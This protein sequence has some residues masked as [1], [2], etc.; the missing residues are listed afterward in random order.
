MGEL[1][2]R[3]M[4]SEA[5]QES[6]RDTGQRAFI[7]E[8][9]ETYPRSRSRLRASHAASSR[10]ETSQIQPLWP[11]AGLPA[12][13]PI[14]VARPRAKS[15]SQTWCKHMSPE[16]EVPRSARSAHH[17]TGERNQATGGRGQ[18]QLAQSPGR[19]AAKGPRRNCRDAVARLGGAG[20]PK[21]CDICPPEE[22]DGPPNW[23]RSWPPVK[24]PANQMDPDS[25]T[26]VPTEPS[27]LPH[28]TTSGSA[29]RCYLWSS[30]ATAGRRSDESSMA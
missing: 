15:Q 6:R 27:I 25:S 3:L 26:P 17:A 5:S 13:R 29:R 22:S 7:C 21:S 19:F 11:D 9:L 24:F 1:S 12:A 18:G 2:C 20:Q 30:V 4:Q 28:R 23:A 14:V 16:M 10:R 8:R